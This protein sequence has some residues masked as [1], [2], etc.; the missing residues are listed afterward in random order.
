MQCSFKDISKLINKSNHIIIT[1]H[2]QPDGDCLGSMLALYLYL[3]DI[4]KKVQ[5]VLDDE[6]PLSF[7]FL[8]SIQEIIRPSQTLCS[9]ADLIIVLDASDIERIGNLSTQTSCPILNIDHHKSNTN[10]AEFTYLDLSAAA[11][12]EIICDLFD[13]LHYDPTQA[14]ANCLYTAIATDC[15]FFRYANTTSATLRKAA[16]LVD[17]GAQPNLISE[18][19]QMRAPEYIAILTGVL[20][21]LEF[22]HN[23]QI[24]AITVDL[25][26]NPLLD[27][28]GFIDYPR[29]IEGIRVA[30]M[31][32]IVDENTIRVSMRS[33]DI[34]V[35][36]I[37]LSFGGGGHLRAA[38][39][40]LTDNY[41]NAKDKILAAIENMLRDD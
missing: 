25:T 6:I 12:G 37:A 4:G 13:Y 36:Q 23:Q 11:T 32:K 17:F 39:C 2:L 18:S 22:F 31:F 15:G 27:S 9:Q 26:K 10:F 35:S 30:I 24:A 34:D 33:T 29:Y 3:Q 21:T 14:I 1:G 20:Q 38:G 40:T 7:R 28:E 19:L 5:V 8:P 16:F 41:L